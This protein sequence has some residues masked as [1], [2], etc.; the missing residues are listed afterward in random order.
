MGAGA[1]LREAKGSAV[2]RTNE[3]ELEEIQAGNQ[4]DEA[5]GQPRAE[6]A[7]VSPAASPP[8]GITQAQGSLNPPIPMG[9]PSAPRPPSHVLP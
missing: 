2:T 7:L 5:S 9:I 8:A 6:R 1:E 3:E 4:K